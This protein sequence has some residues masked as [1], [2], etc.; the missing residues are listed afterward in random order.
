MCYQVKR[1]KNRKLTTLQMTNAQY[2]HVD[3]TNECFTIQPFTRTNTCLFPSSTNDVTFV[4]RTSKNQL[5]VV[6]D[7][8]AYCTT[9]MPQPKQCQNSHRHKHIFP[10]WR[11]HIL[12]V[13]AIQRSPSK[14]NT[15]QGAG[16]GF[17]YTCLRRW[18]MPTL[19]PM[20]YRVERVKNHKATTLQM[21][22]GKYF[23]A[24]LMNE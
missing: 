4:S 16:M 22:K 3:P 9:T 2:F 10:P 6:F 5:A 11:G 14:P 17:A 24:D 19:P 23:H 12:N 15:S 7:N 13:Q 8:L 18:S 20:C 21:T 1:V